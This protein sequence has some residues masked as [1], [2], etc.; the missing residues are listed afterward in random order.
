MCSILPEAL[1][2]AMTFITS[3]LYFLLSSSWLRVVGSI[4]S[5]QAGTI[6]L[7]S[8]ATTNGLQDIVTWDGHSLLIHGERIFFYSAEFHSFRLPS[9]GLWL[10]VFQK[11]KA[12][13]FN[14]VS[15]YVDW[16]LLEGDPGHFCAD[17]VFALDEFF[18]AAS[19]RI[20]TIPR[21][22]HRT[23]FALLPRSHSFT[24]HPRRNRIRPLHLAE[25]NV[26]RLSSPAR[27]ALPATRP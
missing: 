13:G 8:R 16:A 27:R 10:E 19:F 14:G 17:G 24:Y 6:H 22:F 23:T 15:S 5:H 20:T 12:L 4:P 1:S 26:P 9:P 18:E 21:P 25:Q 7:A 3:L 11:I 2:S